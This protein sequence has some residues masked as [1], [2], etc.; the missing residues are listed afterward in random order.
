LA[1]LDS[2]LDAVLPKQFGVSK[3]PWFFLNPLIKLCKRCTAR[4]HI[5][6]GYARS[7]NF[8]SYQFILFYFV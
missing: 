5:S 3:K 4:A 8:N 1:F 2:Y 7:R 6:A